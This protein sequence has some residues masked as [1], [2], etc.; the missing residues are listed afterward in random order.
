MLSA[1]FALSVTGCYVE[2]G[3]AVRPAPATS[4]G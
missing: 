1:M 3:A 4:A 2:T